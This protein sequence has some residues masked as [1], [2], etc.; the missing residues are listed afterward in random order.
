[1]KGLCGLSLRK[2]IEYHELRKSSAP[3][4]SKTINSIL[5]FSKS[6]SYSEIIEYKKETGLI[7]W[8]T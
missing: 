5:N 7:D 1:M 8:P 3:D 6:R 2:N 4:S